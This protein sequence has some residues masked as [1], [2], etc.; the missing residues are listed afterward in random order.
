MIIV[1]FVVVV[2]VVAVAVAWG[3]SVGFGGL[4]L[5]LRNAVHSGAAARPSGT[6]RPLRPTRRPHHAS[7]TIPLSSPSHTRLPLHSPP[8]RTP[9]A[10]ARRRLRL[11]GLRLLRLLGSPSAEPPAHRHALPLLPMFRRLGGAAPS[12]VLEQHRSSRSGLSA[13]RPRHPTSV[14]Q[15]QTQPQPAQPTV[16]CRRHIALPASTTA[17]CT[18]LRSLRPPLSLYCV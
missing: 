18:N 7:R 1:L 5:L 6:P 2:V 15:P 10:S 17:T 14:A 8:D 9:L 12:R 11:I 13:P 4:E 3:V 16:S